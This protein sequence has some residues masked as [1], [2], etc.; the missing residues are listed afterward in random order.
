MSTMWPNAEAAVNR[1]VSRF[2]NVRRKYDSTGPGP[3]TGSLNRDDIRRW[4]EC[5]GSLPGQLPPMLFLQMGAA[6]AVFLVVPSVSSREV[7]C[8]VGL[9]PSSFEPD[10]MY[11][12]PRETGMA[13]LPLSV[14]EWEHY[15]EPLWDPVREKALRSVREFYGCANADS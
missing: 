4:T 1:I 11:S 8:D 7:L 2:A 15:E 6:E 9:P 5:A 10:E 14:D 12:L 3:N 13:S